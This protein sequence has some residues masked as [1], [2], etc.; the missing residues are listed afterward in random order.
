MVSKAISK[1]VRT[2]S[3]KVQRVI[4]L[5]RGQQVQKAIDLLNFCPQK[6]SVIVSKTIKSAIANANVKGGVDIDNLVVSKITVGQ[7][8]TLKRWRARARG[9]AGRINKRTAHITVELKEI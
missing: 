5:V 2:S 9:M 6:A 4:N 1:Y 3:Q 8:P 7:G